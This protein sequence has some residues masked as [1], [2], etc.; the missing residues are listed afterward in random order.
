MYGF[1]PPAEIVSASSDAWR[2]VAE[3]VTLT[4][5]VILSSILL[6]RVV[7]KF[8]QRFTAV[9]FRS[10]VFPES[11]N[12]Q[13]TFNRQVL[14]L[15]TIRLHGR[16]DCLALA[17]AEAE[18]GTKSV[19]N[20]AIFDRRDRGCVYS[21]AGMP[22]SVV[23]PHELRHTL[24]SD[25]LRVGKRP[26]PAGAGRLRLGQASTTENPGGGGVSHDGKGNHRASKI[27]RG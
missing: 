10:S 21:Q 17:I 15:N 5:S 7:Y 2:L 23:A 18:D 19:L 26:A 12:P 22:F 14:E 24:P 1:G 6:R 20:L 27:R 13:A 16:K 4:S 9:A 11:V 25:A 8:L 3:G